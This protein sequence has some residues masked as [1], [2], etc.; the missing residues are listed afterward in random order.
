MKKKILAIVL[1]LVLVFGTLTFV[2]CGKSDPEKYINLNG[3]TLV[4]EGENFEHS[5]T[6]Y[7]GFFSSKIVSKGTF[8]IKDDRYYFNCNER[9]TEVFFGNQLVSSH[10]SIEHYNHFFGSILS[11]GGLLLPL[12]HHSIYL[13]DGYD[14]ITPELDVIKAEKHYEFYLNNYGYNFDT[15]IKV[16]T[17][18][19]KW[20]EDAKVDDESYF[21][22]IDIE[23]E[24]QI[25]FYSPDISIAGWNENAKAGE[26]FNC[27][28]SIKFDGNIYSTSYF[29]EVFDENTLFFENVQCNDNEIQSINR[30]ETM[31]LHE[32]DFNIMYAFLVDKSS[33]NSK[34]FVSVL[35]YNNDD[36]TSTRTEIFFVKDLIN[37]N[38]TGFTLA[39]VLIDGFSVKIPM[40]VVDDT[41]QFVTGIDCTGNIYLSNGQLDLSQ[42]KVMA[43]VYKE[44]EQIEITNIETPH[45]KNRAPK[46]M[47]SYYGSCFAIVDIYGA[48]LKFPINTFYLDPDIR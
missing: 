42:F 40:C 26:S 22:I 10:N 47:E 20:L 32:N 2:G 11:N 44:P 19:E 16:G 24:K 48:R 39:T 8:F 41:E 46:V 7:S 18:A 27:T 30:N 21:Y 1:A 9:L 23:K 6:K 25:K 28:L 38:N 15:R 29:I 4:L 3:D 34:I 37:T 35:N 31:P 17:T 12:G 43:Q 36:T 33:I 14:D 13:K 45:Y 5:F